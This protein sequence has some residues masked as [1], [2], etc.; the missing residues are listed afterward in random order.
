ML[1]AQTGVA[2][3]P[4]S[5]FHA[6]SLAGWLADYGLKETDFPSERDALRAVFRT[7]LERGRGGTNTFGLR[8]QRHSFDHFLQQ[9]E[10]VFPGRMKDAERIGQAFG[11][12]LYVHL[13]RS[14][15]VDQAISLLRAEQTGLWHRRA[16]G[17]ELERLAPPR[18]PR[19]DAG[20]IAQR[21]RELTEQDDAWERWFEKEGLAPLRITYDDLSDDPRKVLAKVLSALGSE[22]DLA[23]FAHAPTARLANDE[24]RQWRRRFLSEI[25]GAGRWTAS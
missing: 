13:S 11:P 3:E 21:I 1:L 23:R 16:D 5:H 10:I 6:P 8:M 20:A 25:D 19:Y 12:T 18:Q 24:S 7:A 22:P 9:L 17:T 2:G 4:D 15:R 14:D